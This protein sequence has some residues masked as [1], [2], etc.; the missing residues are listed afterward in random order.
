MTKK[1][2]LP[3]SRYSNTIDNSNV[4]KLKRNISKLSNVNEMDISFQVRSG[5]KDKKQKN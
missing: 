1:I 2:K 4:N 3:K 5:S